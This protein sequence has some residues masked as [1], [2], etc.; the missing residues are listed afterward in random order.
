VQALFQMDA[1]ATSRALLLKE[2]HEY[3]LGATLDD[4]EFA[5]AEGDFF[6]AIVIGVDED[7]ADIDA[8]IAQRLASGW[9]MERLDP[10]MLQILRA[11]TF[12]LL[13]RSDIATAVVI[14]EYVD[15]ADAFFDER[16]KGFA[17]GLL[18]AIAKEIRSPATS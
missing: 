14:D 15:I 5:G 17:N 3:R 10:T 7:R 4:V 12:E 6:D 2:F 8:L 16:E 1:E 9:T 13:R 18:D 11:G